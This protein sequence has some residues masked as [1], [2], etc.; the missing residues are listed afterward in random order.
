MGGT[1]DFEMKLV[2]RSSIGEILA[3][4]NKLS[5]SSGFVRDGRFYI[6]EEAGARRQPGAAVP[7][8]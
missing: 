2:N 3:Q 4:P 5:I 8:C 1:I 7:A 6:R